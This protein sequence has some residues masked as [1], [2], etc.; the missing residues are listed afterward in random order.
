[1]NE[2]HQDIVISIVDA[3]RAVLR[4]KQVTFDEYRAGFHHLIETAA[5][6]ETGLVLDMFFNQTICD[7]EMQHR[8][9]TRSNVEGPYFLEGAPMVTDEIKVRGDVDPLLIRGQVKDTNDNPLPDV[10]VDIWFSSPDGF[11]S[12][13]ADDYPQEYFRGKLITDKNGRFCVKGSIPGE[14]PITRERHGPTGSLIA[15]L[16][17]QGRRPRHVHQKYRKPGF[18]T[19]TTQAY[20]AGSKYLDEDPVESVFDD[21]VHEVKVEEG[22]KVL[23]LAIV[24]DPS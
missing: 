3:V 13:F 1:M 15:S 2:R 12:G 19:L 9:G 4:E 21:L 17:G 23:T 5:A 7:T 24:L 6:K 14:Y 16:G 20:F 8:M 18:Q 10:D 22:I 11:Y